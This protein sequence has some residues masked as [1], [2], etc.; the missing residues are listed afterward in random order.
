MVFIVLRETCTKHC[1]NGIWRA[2]HDGKRKEGVESARVAIAAV[3]EV[4]DDR[5]Q[6]RSAQAAESMTKVEKNETSS[7]TS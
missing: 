5:L 1:A 3:S 7:E 4:E 6:T 2:L